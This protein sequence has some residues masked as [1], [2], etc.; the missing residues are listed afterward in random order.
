MKKEEK[1]ITNGWNSPEAQQVLKDQLA[2]SRQRILT[3]DLVEAEELLVAVYREMW[4]DAICTGSHG[5][6]ENITEY[7]KKHKL[8]I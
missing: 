7:V 6:R 3:M 4:K 8:I 2:D 5:L 1:D